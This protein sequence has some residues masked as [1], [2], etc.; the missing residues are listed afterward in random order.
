MGVISSYHPCTFTPVLVQ[1]LILSFRDYTKELRGTDRFIP[2]KSD[3]T[4]ILTCCLDSTEEHVT[5]TDILHTKSEK[6]WQQKVSAYQK[7]R[8]TPQEVINYLQQ[9]GLSVIFT[10]AVNRLITMIAKK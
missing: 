9:A 3:D 7:V 1:Q 8:I 5:V 10:E 2:V 6:G 4:G